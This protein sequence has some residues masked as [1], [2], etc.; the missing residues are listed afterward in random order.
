MKRRLSQAEWW[1]E[2]RR[3]FGDNPD[4]WLFVCP[5]C[6][7][8]Q[9]R[10]DWLAYGTPGAEADR[11]LA[12]DCIGIRALEVCPDP[13]TVDFM[14]PSRGTGCRY[15]AAGLFPISPVVVTM[16][17]QH[18]PFERELFEWAHQPQPQEVR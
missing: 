15:T 1:A 16:G 7:Q 18:D 10:L 9:S 2:G 5:S 4:L 17:A 3:L 11:R 12:F 8:I 13:G 14:E 6:G